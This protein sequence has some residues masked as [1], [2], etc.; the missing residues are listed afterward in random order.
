MRLD[1]AV[2]ETFRHDRLVIGL[3]LLALIALA[4]WYLYWDAAR[5][6][7]VGHLEGALPIS[8]DSFITAFIMWSVMMVGMMVPSVAPTI[9]LY[10]MMVRKNHEKGRA[11]AAASIFTAGYLL[12][13]T[14]YS[15]IAA[16]LQMLLTK[17]A[18][19]SPFL[20]ST[21]VYLTAGILI[22][23]GLY[24]W[25]PIKD[26]CLQYCRSP[27][28]FIMARWHPGNFGAVRM[29]FENG[30]YCIGCCWA[31]MLVMFVGGV[32]NLLLMAILAAFFIMEKL[33]P[34]GQQTARVVGALLIGLGVWTLAGGSF[35]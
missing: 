1:R 31:L 15:A 4:W 6:L 27:M 21:S 26:M 10:A 18:L 32:M 16:V 33:A 12:A 24:Q 29:G 20:V 8:F 34:F 11:L 28:N 19:M 14:A 25:L 35:V 7:H 13:W 3:S 17:Y 23:A 22:A 2:E 5:H 30:I 9:L